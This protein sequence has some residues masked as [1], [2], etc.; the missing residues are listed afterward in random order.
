[1]SARLNNE[2]G[3]DVNAVAM[4]LAHAELMEAWPGRKLATV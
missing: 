1:M 3:G 4:A 2:L